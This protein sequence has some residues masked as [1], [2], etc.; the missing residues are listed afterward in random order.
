MEYKE[1]K[2]MTVK[3]TLIKNYSQ[4]DVKEFTNENGETF[5]VLNITL[6]KKQ[7]TEEKVYINCSIFGEN[8]GDNIEKFH[9]RKGDQL[10]AFGYFKLHEK[11]EKIFRDFI[12]IDY[13]ITDADEK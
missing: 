8:F 5:S 4:D 2:M 7:E 9:F 11:G 1:R 6:L 12:I 3:G 10:S 13:V